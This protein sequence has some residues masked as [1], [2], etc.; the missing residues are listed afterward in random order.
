MALAESNVET[1]DA[2]PGPRFLAPAARPR[3]LGTD[4][5]TVIAEAG[6]AP[7]LDVPMALAFLVHG[8]YD[9]YRSFFHDVSLAPPRAPERPGTATRPWATRTES[10][11]SASP[12]RSPSG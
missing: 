11:S 6:L 1:G 9:A 8:E 3:H 2:D 5:L 10:A 4:A 7:R 12:A